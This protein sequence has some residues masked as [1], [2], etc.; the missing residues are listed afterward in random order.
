M[1]SEKGGRSPSYRRIIQFFFF[2]FQFFILIEKN[3]FSPS[4]PSVSKFKKVKLEYDWQQI[5]H[6]IEQIVD[7]TN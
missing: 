1:E 3:I 6:Y 2:L 4:F 7:K 5:Y